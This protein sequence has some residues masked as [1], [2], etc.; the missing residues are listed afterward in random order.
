MSMIDC[1]YSYRIPRILAIPLSVLFVFLLFTLL[2]WA[3]Y[4]QIGNL[5]HNLPSYESNVR[6]KV[7]KI[8]TLH[9]YISSN[10]NEVRTALKEETQPTLVD[11]NSTTTPIP[12]VL[13]SNKQS[14]FSQIVQLS[15]ILSPILS[16][17]GTML[18]TIVFLLYILFNRQDLRERLILLIS[19][20]DLN[21]A[22]QAI[23]DTASRI[24]QYLLSN[25]CTNGILGAVIGL[26]LYI[27]GVPN[28]LLWGILTI[29]LRFIP[30]LGV[31]ISASFPLILAF[32]VDPGWSMLIMT[33][34][35]YIVA[36]FATN[37]LLEPRLYGASTGLSS[38]SVMAA[39]VFWTWLWGIVGLFL[40]VPLTVCIFMLGKYVAGLEFLEIILSSDP[41]LKPPSHLYQRLLARDEG[42]ILKIC[43]D[44]IK[45]N[46]LIDYYDQLLI[47]TLTLAKRDHFNGTLAEHRQ[48][49]I[50][51][52]AQDLIDIVKY[53]SENSI[54][55][56]P[57]NMS[58]IICISARDEF[59][60][61]VAKMLANCLN[62][63]G[64][65]VVV[66]EC[67]ASS[68]DIK[69]F[70]KTHNQPICISSLPPYAISPARHLF[71]KIRNNH[72]LA[73]II[74]GIWGA[75][76]SGVSHLQ[77]AWEGSEGI[78]V[79]LKETVLQTKLLLGLDQQNSVTKGNIE[80][81]QQKLLAKVNREFAKIPASELSLT[82]LKKIARTVDVPLSLISLLEIDS[83]FWRSNT[84]ILPT[85]NEAQENLRQSAACKYVVSN[86]ETL[87]VPNLKKDSRFNTDTWL[88]DRGILFFAGIPLL[89]E[90]EHVVGILCVI[91]TKSREMSRQDLF[92]LEALA[93]VFMKKILS[94][95][96]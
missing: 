59:D 31:W 1:L 40:S 44:F 51:E 82:V 10:L 75:G 64:I 22:T 30:F 38:I 33:I 41:S 76:C 67:I 80:S 12:V 34:G 92:M 35:L 66:I 89:S 95:K 70:L 15:P 65:S 24:T 58:G 93:K 77:S 27:I 60:E 7:Q 20:D 6:L 57:D 45:K 79:T 96:K 13:H 29:F 74:I 72:T 26:G 49:F 19:Q 11:K 94:D 36:E 61:L 5:T 52:N 16:P 47:P 91:D 53:S 54:K 55:E 4:V 62:S 48:Q 14:F 28:A 71:K 46:T 69:K 17:L 63:E 86:N 8:N 39:S 83:Y 84:G 42:E 87:L 9:E 81:D 73:K 50:L 56:P 68:E 2:S 18:L 78:V 88:A 32:A 37:Y 23:D 85:I 90:A 21:L 3:V 43:T 25:L